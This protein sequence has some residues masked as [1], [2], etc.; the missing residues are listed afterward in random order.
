M[1]KRGKWNWRTVSFQDP[2]VGFPCLYD[3]RTAGIDSRVTGK[4]YSSTVKKY[5]KTA[6]SSDHRETSNYLFLYGSDGGSEFLVLE[7]CK[8][9]AETFYVVGREHHTSLKS[10]FRRIW[11]EN[12]IC[13]QKSSSRIHARPTST[14]STTFNQSQVFE[15]YVA[16]VALHAF[17]I[18]RASFL[19]ETSPS[20]YLVSMCITLF[21]CVTSF[22]YSF[23]QSWNHVLSFVGNPLSIWDCPT[24]STGR[25]GLGTEGQ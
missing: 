7:L 25:Y 1:E 20:F 23:V 15:L 13:M 14:T 18:D 24:W 11:N 17:T 2:D 3:W 4:F 21:C 16:C 9:N 19:V 12:K 10:I 5:L 8:G 22:C 6:C